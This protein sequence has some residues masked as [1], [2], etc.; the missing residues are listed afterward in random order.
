MGCLPWLC[1]NQA[2]PE[3]S[4]GQ[5]TG[6]AH[7]RYAESSRTLLDLPRL[8]R[9][10]F[11]L[12]FGHLA[13]RLPFALDVERVVD[14]YVLMCMLVGNDFL[15]GE[16][17]VLAMVLAMGPTVYATRLANVCRCC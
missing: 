2:H 9:E 11:E 17:A 13:G 3:G 16:G 14:D 7:V 6:R 1:T 5:R 8:L 12:E 15:P 4:R 10:Y